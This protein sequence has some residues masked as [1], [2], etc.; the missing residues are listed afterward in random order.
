MKRIKRL[1]ENNRRNENSSDYTKMSSLIGGLFFSGVGYTV[2]TTG[3]LVKDLVSSLYAE[4]S[5]IQ[6]Y[7][8]NGGGYDLINYLSEIVSTSLAHANDMGGYGA[9]IGMIGGTVFFG[10]LRNTISSLLGK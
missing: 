1:R 9:A 4:M 8:T 7:V 10:K 5:V 3:F 2:T 6:S